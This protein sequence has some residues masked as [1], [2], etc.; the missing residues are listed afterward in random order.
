MQE[1]PISGINA[2]MRKLA[3]SIPTTVQLIKK[4]DDSYSLNT[5]MWMLSTSQKFLLGD[6]KDVTTT[7]GRKVKSVFTIEGNNLI[8]R[9]MGEK[10]LLI[11]REFFDEE[12]IATTSM[13]DVVCKAWCKLVD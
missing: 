6:E 11:V 7:D 4:P 3:S 9:Q 13:G 8:E 1:K 10:T 12:M 5:F 2:I